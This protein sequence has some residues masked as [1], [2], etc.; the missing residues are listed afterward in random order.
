[1]GLILNHKKLE[2]GA[3]LISTDVSTMGVMPFM[4]LEY[5]DGETSSQKLERL[6]SP[7]VMKTHLP[8][9]LYED[10]LL[11]NPN[12]KVIQTVRNPK[13]T[14]VSYFYHLK[15]IMIGGL[16]TGTWDQFFEELVKKQKLP[17]GDIFDVTAKWYKFNKDRNNS[18]VLKYEDMKK[19]HRG[20]VIEIAEFMGFHLSDKVIDLIVQKTCKQQMRED[21]NEFLKKTLSS[22]PSGKGERSKKASAP[23]QFVRKGEV[24]DWVNYFSQEQ[25]EYVDR[26]C[27]EYFKPLGLTFEYA[28]PR[29]YTHAYTR[30]HT[31]THT[32]IT[33]L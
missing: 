6:D 20:H 21:T 26:Q 5:L 9:E 31:H 24:G 12:L 10:L 8:F 13:D 33:H 30:E 1:M 32:H 25:S 2:A 28:A 19:D 27:E 14:L 18:L 17:W 22:R 15:H 29:T 16:F 3:T 4:E 11:R 23:F 7:R